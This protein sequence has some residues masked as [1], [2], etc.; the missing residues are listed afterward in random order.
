ML[1][2][3]VKRL[4]N[5]EATNKKKRQKVGL[6]LFRDGHAER[7]PLADFIPLFAGPEARE[8]TRIE[9]GGPGQGQLLELL[10]GLI[11]ENRTEKE[12]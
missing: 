2:D 4:L 6:A 5:L 8:I 7:K 10:T 11:E 3:H 1:K 9:G 12:N